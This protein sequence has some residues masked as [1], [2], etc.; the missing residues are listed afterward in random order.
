MSVRCEHRLLAWTVTLALMAGVPGSSARADGAQVL[1]VALPTGVVRLIE[2]VAI[3]YV[4]IY[5]DGGTVA[6]G[7]RDSR[8]LALKLCFGDRLQTGLRRAQPPHLYVGAYHWSD[9]TAIQLPIGGAEERVIL[10]W[11]DQGLAQQRHAA[12][13]RMSDPAVAFRISLVQKVTS[14]IR[15]RQNRNRRDEQ[16]QIG[17]ARRKVVATIG[18]ARRSCFD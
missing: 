1:G 7:L 8:G 17:N 11:L 12:A 13:E 5:R 4:D 15:A 6:I 2:P 16:S 10:D 9:P 3:D 18:S 14:A